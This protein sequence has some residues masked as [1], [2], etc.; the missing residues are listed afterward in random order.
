VKPDHKVAVLGVR[1]EPF[2]RE[3][4]ARAADV[5][6]RRRPNC[7]VIFLAVEGPGDLP[8]IAASRGS[9]TGNGGIWVV[10]PKG[11]PDLPQQTVIEAIVAAGLVDNKGIRFSDTHAALRAVFRLRDR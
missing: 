5:S 2:L 3:L 6:Y 11:R 8:K 9:I 7:D 4:R 1:D 10:H